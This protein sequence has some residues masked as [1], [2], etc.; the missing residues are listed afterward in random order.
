MVRMARL[1]NRTA[2]ETFFKSIQKRVESAKKIRK[3]IRNVSEMFLAPL[4][5]L[6]KIYIYIYIFTGTF[7]KVFHYP[8][9]TQKT[10]FHRETLQG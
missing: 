1:Q 10:L 5:P 2:P 6:K 8:K 3:T 7:L 4:R 9:F